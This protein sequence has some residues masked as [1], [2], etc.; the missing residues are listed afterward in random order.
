MPDLKMF[1]PITKVDLERRLVYGIA[2][3]ETADR[4]GEVCDYATTK[5]FYEKWSA[6]IHK[7]TD[8]K[9]LG[10]VR[11]M[12]GKVAAGK[13]TTINFNDDAKNIEICAK[14]VDDAEWNKVEEG[15]YTGFSQGG[16]YVKRWKDEA[17]AQRYT[18]DPSEVSLVD[19]PCLPEATFKVLKADGA[20]EERRFV[21]PAQIGNVEVA[22]RAE[23]L[24]K[25]AG[26]EPSTWTEYIEAARAELTKAAA[27]FIKEAA[28]VDPARPPVPVVEKAAADPVPADPVADPKAAAT[29]ND[30]VKQVWMSKDDKPFAKKADAIAHNAQIDAQA[31][32][33]T[34]TDPMLSEVRKLGAQFGI[35]NADPAP[36]PDPLGKKDY[37]DTDR[38]KMATAGEAMKD[39]SY[40]IKNKGDLSNAITA[41]GRAKN[42]T[43]A[44]RHITKRAKALDLTDMLPADWSGSTKDKSAKA[45]GGDLA[46]G[47]TLYSISN[48]VQLLASVESAEDWMEGDNDYSGTAV[49]REITTRFGTVLVDLGDVVADV[50]DLLLDAMKDEEAS[51]AL[52]AAAPMGNLIKLG[53]RTSKSDK[54]KLQA[55]H[56][57]TV[58][59]GATCDAENAKAASGAG[60]SKAA[61]DLAKMTGERDSLLAKYDALNKTLT[62]DFMPLIKA[63]AAQPV[64]QHLI[65]RAI[66][67]SEDADGSAAP[68]A[69]EVEEQFLKMDP[70]AQARLIIKISQRNP[71]QLALGG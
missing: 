28:V 8:G 36:E 31:A 10:N 45:A 17:G 61:D 32:V 56:D 41:Y 40:P 54:A 44:K 30:L 21:M 29:D 6:D 62:D 48:L 15:V 13:V 25:A 66:T 35:K 14:I 7:A 64:P 18:A 58:D 24:A 69:K 60:L 67:K 42:K 12:H 37:S 47:A 20:E 16:A 39:G 68:E 49:P 3:G 71:H 46:K 5:P 26:K 9:S 27:A 70:D 1:I 23:E 65:G 55:M 51:E 52:A 11:A 4:V 34:T 53:A 38:T 19:L 33:R 50:L 22:K 59:M 2:T 43:A 57:T 63:I